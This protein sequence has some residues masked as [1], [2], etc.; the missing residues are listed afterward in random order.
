MAMVE[1]TRLGGDHVEELVAILLCRKHPAAVRVRPSAGD[2]GIDLL[3]PASG[4]GS[5]VY[6]VKKFSSNLTASQKSQIEESL[7]RLEQYRIEHAIT[8]S[9]WHLTLPLDP[10]NENLQWLAETTKNLPY[11]C[12]WRGLSFVDGLAAEFPDVVDYYV[13]D[14]RRRLEIVVGQLTSAMGMKPND[15]D[16]I[17]S[18]SQLSNY[19]QSLAPVL[20]TDPHFRYE[21]SLGPMKPYVMS[22]PN[23]ILAAINSVGDANDN[24]VTVCVFPRFAAA[25]DFR[26]IPIEVV[27]RAEPDSELQRELAS[28]VKYG[29]S[30]SAPVG[31]VDIKM[32]MPGGLGGDASNA[33]LRIMSA[34]PSVP[35]RVL[36]MAAVDP[37]DD[38][39]GYVLID[40]QP[41]TFGIDGTGAG[42]TGTERGGNFRVQM[43]SDLSAQ[44]MNLTIS[45]ISFE[46]HAPHE[47][48]AALSFLNALHPPNR[49]AIAAQHGPITN[50]MTLPGDFCLPDGDL[51]QMLAKT[52][53]SLATIQE[54]TT[55]QLVMPGSISAADATN[56]RAAERLL[57][58]EEV[59]LNTTGVRI[60]LHPGVSVPEG[61]FA[62]AF[63]SDFAV[64]VGAAEVPIGTILTHCSIAEV[65]PKSV[66]HHDDHMD[67]S[68]RPA[69]NAVVTA[70]LVP[71]Q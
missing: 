60:C 54:H 35:S 57:L 38:V 34:Q 63:Y 3:A 46:G 10:T 39:V 67:C 6:Q 31:T 20:D 59:G 55:A 40:M 53:A 9:A 5:E 47:V 25:L 45:G 15:G 68:F 50:P 16:G 64:T 44:T 66:E 49:L 52:A 32:D 56:W 58:G 23:L 62:I 27:I 1:W 51:L 37:D 12:H 22:E 30:V 70:R 18:P 29:T 42:T 19:L 41:A 13:G 61:K 7:R 48:V 11:P 28:F 8:V 36:R 21:V 4:G 33:G 43:L 2:G 69:D 24:A 65:D 71:P 17:V 14:G 26:P